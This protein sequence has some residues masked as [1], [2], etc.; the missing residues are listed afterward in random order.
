MAGLGALKPWELSLVFAGLAFLAE[1]TV[2]RKRVAR[3][4]QPPPF[5]T[6]NALPV[7]IAALAVGLALVAAV[8]L[9]IWQ[10]DSLGYHLP[11]VAYAL[12]AGSLAGVPWALPYIG[13]YPHGVELWDLGARALLPN[14]HWLDVAQL[15]L[16]LC[17]AVAIAGL[18][19]RVGASAGTAVAVAGL[20]LCLPAV[21]LQLPSVYVDVAS[22]SFFLLAALWIVSSPFARID[23][24]GRGFA[25][26]VPEQQ[27]IFPR[28]NAGPRSWLRNPRLARR[29]ARAF[30]L[31]AAALALA[32]GS[33]SYLTNLASHGNPL[34]PVRIDLGPIHL[35]GQSSLGDL[36]AA[37]AAAPRLS[38]SLPS[39]L[40]RSWATLDSRPA[41]DMRVGGF[42]PAVSLL[43]AA[44]R[45]VGSVS[46]RR[47]LGDGAG[48]SAPDG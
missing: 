18:A 20:W 4:G 48:G 26:T 21:F 39:R 2:S 6:A 13:S 33:E 43:C 3:S 19:R 46:P 37:G 38:G 15:P 31:F 10:W 28:R 14:D 22:A 42:G 40:L 16:C 7:A 11:F 9:P 23:G 8:G 30:R 44:A 5:E 29:S 32:L 45:A 27:A 47:G 24:S 17:G 41:F 25:G 35:Q 1:L 36:L 12:Q 34:W